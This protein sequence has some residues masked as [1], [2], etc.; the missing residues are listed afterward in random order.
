MQLRQARLE[1]EK[2]ASRL[3]GML[4]FMACDLCIAEG[5]PTGTCTHFGGRCLFSQPPR[6]GLVP[7]DPPPINPASATNPLQLLAPPSLVQSAV[8]PEPVSTLPIAIPTVL[9]RKPPTEGPEEKVKLEKLQLENDALRAAQADRNSD[10]PLELKQMTIGGVHKLLEVY[11][12]RVAPKER[13]GSKWRNTE[14]LGSRAEMKRIGTMLQ[15]SYEPVLFAVLQ[16]HL[17]Q[18]MDLLKA[19]ADLESLRSPGDWKFIQSLPKVEGD[20]LTRYKKHLNSEDFEKLG[21]ITLSP[22]KLV[23]I[24]TTDT[25]DAMA[26]TAT[27][28]K[29]TTTATIS[30]TPLVPS[31][32][33]AV[34]YLSVDPG[35][36]CGWSILHVKDEQLVAVDCGVLKVDKSLT[37]TG[38]RCL[39]LQEQLRLLL[40]PPPVHIF[41][42]A[43][44][45]SDRKKNGLEMNFALRAA[46]KMELAAHRLEYQEVEFS[47]WMAIIA[48]GRADKSTTQ[49]AIEQRFGNVFPSHLPIGGSNLKFRH[50][51]S[52]A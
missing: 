20:T 42:E 40:T 46:I 44:H 34:R 37:C 1:K 47:K 11:L 8:V 6:A 16:R 21:L 28:A 18:G 52:D 35:L 22:P 45:V 25:T 51:A 7:M 13:H 5:A 49:L 50:D 29:T 33:G 9:D 3:G 2:K 26:T 14:T 23:P 19:V 43:Y 36:S 27:N 48:T 15:T 39:S 24:T 10:L 30:P 4:K 41:T 38:A 12:T 31:M 17:D 32:E